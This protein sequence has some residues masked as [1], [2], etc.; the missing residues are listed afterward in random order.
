MSKVLI[1]ILD[2]VSETSM[3]FN[4][5]VLWRTKHCFDEK[6]IL[7][8]IGNK[9]RVTVEFPERLRIVWIARDPFR[10]RKTIKE[11][12]ADLKMNGCEY[13]IHLHQLKSASLV[14]LAMIGTG[15]RKKTVF[16]IHSTFSGYA[17]HNKIQSYFNGLMARY[18]S[19]VSEASYAKYPASLKKIKGDRV[20]AIRNGVDIGRIDDVL[21]DVV[22]R[23]EKGM[24][25]FIYVARIIPLKNHPFLVDVIKSTNPKARF[26]FVGQEGDG[27]IRSH[28]KE[29]GLEDRIRLTGLVPRKNVFELLNNSDFYVSTS[30][31]EGMPISVL[32]A[33]YCK[34]PAILSNI[35]QHQ[36]IGGNEKYV[37]YLPFEKEIWIK[38]I[39]KYVEMSEDERENRGEEGKKY[40][41]ANFSLRTMHQRYTE[42]YNI[43]R[44]C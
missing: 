40:V 39:N 27:R 12:L 31:L 10:I 17:L 13:A 21:S 16:T 26:V 9:K 18:V 43:L 35:P 22:C 4:E 1:T 6:E 5:F 34:L 30:T 33:M 3:P 2:G 14:Q 29:A 41:E 23:K 38:E 37:S 11:M 15:F 8:I 36:E 25:Q 42:I 7:I 20:I 44:K 28:I 24:V 19:C 32:E